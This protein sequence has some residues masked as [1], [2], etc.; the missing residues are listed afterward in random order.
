MGFNCLKARLP[1]LEIHKFYNFFFK[2]Q[3]II[4]GNKWNALDSPDSTCMLLSKLP[5]QLRDR[6][7]RKEH[8]I[9]AKH[10]RTPELK[11]LINY[12]DKEKTLFHNRHGH[13]GRNMT[14]NEMVN[15]AVEPYLSLCDL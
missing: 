8:F 7:N 14:L 9:R 4:S 5:G 6:W 3:S 12:V 15:A 11:D 10:S 2:C 13:N 1:G